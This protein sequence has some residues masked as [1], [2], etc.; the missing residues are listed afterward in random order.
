MTEGTRTE[1]IKDMAPAS[2][3][4]A[5]ARAELDKVTLEPEAALEK[6]D[7]QQDEEIQEAFTAAVPPAENTQALESPLLIT[8]LDGKTNNSGDHYSGVEMSQGEVA[9]DSDWNESDPDSDTNADLISGTNDEAGESASL[10]ASAG[11]GASASEGE[12]AETGAS[13]ASGASAGFGASASEGEGAE[14]GASAASGASAGFG[15]S[16]SAS[17]GSVADDSV[18][19]NEGSGAG[20]SGASG[21]SAGFGTSASIGE[22]SEAGASASAGKGSGAI[23]GSADSLKNAS[24]SLKENDEDQPPAD[25]KSDAIQKNAPNDSVSASGNEEQRPPIEEIDKIDHFTAALGVAKDEVGDF[26]VPGKHGKTENPAPDETTAT[27]RDT[28][29]WGDGPAPPG[30]LSR[31]EDSLPKDR[32]DQGPTATSTGDSEDSSSDWSSESS[33]LR[34]E[35]F[36]DLQESS[37]A[38][39][40]NQEMAGEEIQ[41]TSFI[42]SNLISFSALIIIDQAS[43][44]PAEATGSSQERSPITR[45]ALWDFPNGLSEMDFT[46]EELE[47]SKGKANSDPLDVPMAAPDSIL[48]EPEDN[49]GGRI[50][51]PGISEVV[52][53]RKGDARSVPEKGLSDREARD[54]NE[55]SKEI[56]QLEE[57]RILVSGKSAFDSSAGLEN[58]LNKLSELYSELVQCRDMKKDLR[59]EMSM[60]QDELSDWPDGEVK[61][62]TYR[63]LNKQPDGSFQVI[64]KTETLTKGQAKNKLEH[65]DSSVDALEDYIESL[66]QQIRQL[67][68]K[69]ILEARQEAIERSRL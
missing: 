61:T 13:A 7:F 67:E 24:Q 63:E 30:S 16:A 22:G 56:Y 52:L 21:V 8:S 55:N 39:K 38:A 68:N 54:I 60:F 59:E 36:E 19:E 11:F 41:V 32:V 4:V 6:G 9:Q 46:S 45:S 18:S 28:P 37:S 29:V 23:E 44:E 47:F 48:L 33:V 65:L 34:V 25:E 66:L 31:V 14:T 26:R 62:I 58:L 69:D 10:G 42:S 64:D 40:D 43:E 17:E 35:P 20:A 15:A 51:A 1:D 57:G 2:K 50:T 3:E 27:N 12:G 53:D 5:E 49:D